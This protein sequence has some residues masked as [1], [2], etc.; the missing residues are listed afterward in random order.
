MAEVRISDAEWRVMEV[1]W[2]RKSATASEVVRALEADTGWR[3][4]TTRTLLGRLVDKGALEAAAD[5]GRSVYRPLVTR[6]RC[7]REEGRSFLRKVFGGD[8]GELLAHFLRE[9]DLPPDR[10][11]E[12][13]RLLDQKRPGR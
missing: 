10:L 13:R 1:V 11:A 7:I 6:A 9:A 8:T 12:L 3:T 2:E 4:R 5:R